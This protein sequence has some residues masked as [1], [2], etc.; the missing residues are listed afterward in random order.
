MVPIAAALSK[1]GDFFSSQPRQVQPDPALLGSAANRICRVEQTASRGRTPVSTSFGTGFLVGR[2]T[3]IT[4]A[5][6]IGFPFDPNLNYSIS[7][8]FP[9]LGARFQA[10]DAVPESNW[11]RDPRVGSPSDMAALR[12]ASVTAGTALQVGAPGGS[13]VRTAGFPQRFG[14]QFHFSEG[15]LQQTAGAHLLHRAD[16]DDGSSGAPL[17][18]PVGNDVI[19][20]GIH[21]GGTALASIWTGLDR[22]NLAIAG[23]LDRFVANAMGR[24]E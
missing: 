17:L 10:T 18:R 4:C 8:F 11:E 15:K 20:C 23:S 22:W 21:I 16:T 24:Y 5:H 1:S 6:V 14:F 12:I 2:R 13:M 7:V 19:V 9:T 3:V